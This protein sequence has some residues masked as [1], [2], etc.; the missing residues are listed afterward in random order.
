MHFCTLLD[1]DIF[2]AVLLKLTDHTAV[3]KYHIAIRVM[4]ANL[5]FMLRQEAI[6]ADPVGNVVR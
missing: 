6:V 5:A 1:F 2:F 3:D 4:A